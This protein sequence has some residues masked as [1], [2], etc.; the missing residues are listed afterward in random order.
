MSVKTVK[1]GVWRN[2]SFYR[3]LD[4]EK[5]RAE[6]DPYRTGLGRSL[7]PRDVLNWAK[8]HPESETY[9]RFEWD[10]TKAADNYR[11][12]QASQLI[13]T[14][15]MVEKPVVP[16]QVVTTITVETPKQP[17]ITLDGPVRWL[18][19][20]GKQ[21]HQFEYSTIEEIANDTEA[22]DYL[23]TSALRR[24]KALKETYEMYSRGI[25]YYRNV[26][27]FLDD[28]IVELEKHQGRKE[29]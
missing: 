18:V 9:K 2:G 24:L 11:M 26:V 6:L 21:G 13:C 20:C 27:P 16:P 22:C 28:A 8:E 12:Q 3:H 25:A 4:A 23:L 7:V 1:E 15:Y 17:E 10:D 14:V 29:S 19:P 5:I